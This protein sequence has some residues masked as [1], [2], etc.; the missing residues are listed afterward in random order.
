MNAIKTDW[1]AY[2]LSITEIIVRFYIVLGLGILLGVLNAPW[3][4]FLAMLVFL[5][6]ILGWCPVYAALGINHHK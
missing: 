6:G 2:N 3:M 4:V 5:T 1:L